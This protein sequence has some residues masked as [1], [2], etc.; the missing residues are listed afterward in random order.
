MAS[1]NPAFSRNPVF[2]GKAPVKPSATLSADGLQAMYDAPT[3]TAADTDRMSYDDVIVK[4]G[5]SFIV[6]LAFAAVGWQIPA[7][8]IP[9][10]LIGF[11]LAM[12]NIFKREPSAPLILLYAGAQGLFIGAISSF[13]ERLFPGVVVQAVIATIC[14]FAVTLALFASG[15]IRA[16]KRNTKIFMIALIGYAVFSLVNFVLVM[17]GVNKDAFGLSSSVHLFG[18][19]L[20]V[21][22]GVVATLLAA[23]MLVLDFDQIKT[24]VTAGA[25]RKYGWSAAFGLVVTLV[26]LYTQLLRMFA[27]AR[28]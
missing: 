17:T 10:A 7:L 12:V 1:Q 28:N 24:G 11:G 23:Y 14:V 25:P 26:F 15:K 18:I 2:N 19:P 13:F 20:G 3:A 8:A 22:L 4:T 21:V 16:S 5:I 6:L 9:G 27:I